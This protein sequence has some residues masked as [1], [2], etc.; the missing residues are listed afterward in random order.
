VSDATIH[1]A[2][3]DY[4]VGARTAKLHLQAGQRGSQVQFLGRTEIFHISIASQLALG[5]P[6][7]ILNEYWRF[8][9]QPGDET[10]NWTP[11]SA[12]V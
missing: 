8:F 5:G 7:S 11:P 3:F 6:S 10:D 2:N 9:P 1:F 4:S 12:E